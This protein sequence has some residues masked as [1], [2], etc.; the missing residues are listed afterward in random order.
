MPARPAAATSMTGELPHLNR[1]AAER[2]ARLLTSFAA[3]PAGGAPVADASG[4]DRQRAGT[5]RQDPDR[6]DDLTS[7]VRLAFHHR[8]PGLVWHEFGRIHQDDPRLAPL[9]DAYRDASARHLGQLAQLA[10]LAP[11]LSE[12]DPTWMVIKGPVV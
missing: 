8:L 6:D 3:E 4:P 9:A 11:A 1:A 12:A 7:L 5:A 2:V 10:Q